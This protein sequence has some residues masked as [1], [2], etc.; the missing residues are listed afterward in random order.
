MRCIFAAS[1]GSAEELFQPR[2]NQKVCHN[3]FFIHNNMLQNK[4]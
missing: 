2:I 3:I 4:P 1:S